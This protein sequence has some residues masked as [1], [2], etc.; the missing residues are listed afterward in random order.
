MKSQTKTKK[1]FLGLVARGLGMGAADVV[2]GVSGGT[3]AFITGIYEEFLATISGLKFSLFRTW[4]QE[5]FKAMWEQINGRFLIA[6]FLG[7]G[8]SIVSLAKLLTYLLDTQ[9]VLLWSFFFGLILASIWLVGK[10]VEKWNLQNILGLAIGAIVA[11]TITILSPSTGSESLLYIF[12]CGSL[13]ICAMILPGISGSFILLLLGAYTTVL[14]SITGILDGLKIKDWDVVM[15]NGLTVVVFM[16]G[17]VIGLISFSR[18]LNYLFK[19][20]KNLIIAVLTGFLVGSL[21][22]IWPWKETTEWRI[23]RHGEKVAV[24]QQ[25]IS[26]SKFETLFGNSQLLYAVLLALAGLVLIITL[27]YFGNKKKATQA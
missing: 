2:P 24:V 17:C 27:E 22:K 19:K 13:A 4:K 12:L 5:G 11:F 1:S 9:E 7:I 21:N 18:F 8:I 25:N 23:D 26:P 6:I 10:T 14:G 3:I 20:S 16:I 15:S